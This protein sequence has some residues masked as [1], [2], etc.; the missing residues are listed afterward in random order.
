MLIL[1]ERSVVAQTGSVAVSADQTHYLGDLVTNIGVV[2]A[3]LLATE[4]GW[5]A[6]RS[7]HRLA[8]G[9]GAGGQ[10]LAR[11]PPQLGPADGPRIA[12]RRPR[13]DH[14]HRPRHPEVQR[15]HE[16]EDPRRQALSIFIQVHIELD[17]DMPLAAGACG[18][19]RGGAATLRRLSRAE[20]I[21]HQDPAGLEAGCQDRSAI[22]GKLAA[23][24]KPMISRR[25]APARW[26][27]PGARH[28][29]KIGLTSSDMAITA[30]ASLWP[31][32]VSA[33]TGKPGAG[34]DEGKFSHRRQEQRGFAAPCERSR[35]PASAAAS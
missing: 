16:S 12:R 9:G 11:V 32:A 14:R 27:G 34:D 13:E 24:R 25:L 15:L 6:G 4:L 23:G 26:R 19:R 21:I 17:P 28:R 31:A 1:Y 33:P 7:H 10:R 29:N 35:P 20:V 3:I 2:V 8:G 18:Q 22:A 30:M 5:L